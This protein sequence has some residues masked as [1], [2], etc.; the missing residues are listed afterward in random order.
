VHLELADDGSREINPVV[1]QL[2]ETERTITGLPEAFQQP[3][4]LV[5]FGRHR[6]I[7][8]PVR[9]CGRSGRKGAGVRDNRAT[10]D[11]RLQ[12]PRASPSGLT[13]PDM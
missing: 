13:S 8:G 9:D 2:G 5:I 12:R 11:P 6:G 10:I 7:I 4:L 3:H 1:V